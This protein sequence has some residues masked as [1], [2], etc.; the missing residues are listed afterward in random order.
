MV[1]EAEGLDLADVVADLSVGVEAGQV[2]AGAEVGVP[3][4]AR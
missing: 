3:G 2:V 1:I 4:G